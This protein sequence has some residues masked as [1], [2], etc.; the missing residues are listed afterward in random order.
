MERIEGMRSAC[1]LL[2]CLGW[3]LTPG[4]GCGQEEDGTIITGEGPAATLPYAYQ[5]LS[6]FVGGEAVAEF[7]VKMQYAHLME[8]K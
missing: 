2:A 6:Y 7:Q 3:L 5:I 8:N 1:L 4:D